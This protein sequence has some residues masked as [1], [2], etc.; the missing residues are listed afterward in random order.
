MFTRW[1]TFYSGLPLWWQC[2]DIVVETLAVVLLWQS[3]FYGFPRK[4][5][6]FNRGRLLFLIL[7]T[8]AL[9]AYQ[10]HSLIADWKYLP[11]APPS[12]VR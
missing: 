9:S 12:A 2:I 5:V 3:I 11:H 8:V 1:F 7:T 10:I 6:S 4:R